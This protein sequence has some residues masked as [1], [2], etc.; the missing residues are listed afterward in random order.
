MIRQVNATFFG[1]FFSNFVIFHIFSV[2]ESSGSTNEPA[3]STTSPTT[4]IS[5]VSESSKATTNT[6]ITETSPSTITTV[7]SPTTAIDPC[8]LPKD[9]GSCQPPDN[10]SAD[11]NPI[12]R[13]FF[14]NVQ[15][16]K[17][18]AFTFAG[19]G[20]NA[21]NF[22]T[23]HEC[24]AL[25]QTP[26][27]DQDQLGNVIFN[28]VENEVIVTKVDFEIGFPVNWTMKDMDV[29]E[30]DQSVGHV[31]IPS[32]LNGVP[33]QGQ[34]ATHF[35]ISDKGTFQLDLKLKIQNYNSSLS[36]E[37]NP[38][39]EILLL[40]NISSNEG[41]KET[42]TVASTTT[43]ITTQEPNTN[44]SIIKQETDDEVLE[45]SEIPDSA[46]VGKASNFWHLDNSED[47][48]ESHKIFSS[49]DYTLYFSQVAKESKW[50]HVR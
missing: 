43:V 11:A 25:C 22:I 50:I 35:D 38:Y 18:Q 12:T 42:S 20:G 34:F 33:L 21:N 4:T 32:V 1:F 5:T 8:L 40:R 24:Q 28:P 31:L 13:F 15:S 49:H 37:D 17:C 7:V 3:A 46:A 44:K 29:I 27:G 14:D 45:A 9:I 48:M 36:Q 30:M 6:G 19:C 41:P 10:N 16:K 26:I 39:L 47:E 2:P 23:M